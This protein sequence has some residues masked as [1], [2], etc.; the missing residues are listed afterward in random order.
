MGAA[1]EGE[2]VDVGGAVVGPV[3][4]VVDLAQVSGHMAAGVGA[5]AVAGVQHEALIRARDA[6]RTSEI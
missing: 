6:L 1:G 2:V 4:D 3:G 5:A